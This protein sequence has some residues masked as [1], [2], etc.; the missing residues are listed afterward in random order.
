MKS[1]LESKR[2]KKP[3]RYVDRK[4]VERMKGIVARIGG[5]KRHLETRKGN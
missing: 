2:R 3:L 1:H 4:P 5:R